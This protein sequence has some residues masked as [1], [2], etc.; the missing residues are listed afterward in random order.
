MAV[1]PPDTP[2]VSCE[3]QHPSY[4]YVNVVVILYI[5]VCIYFIKT[6]KLFSKYRFTVSKYEEIPLVGQSS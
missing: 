2:V 4:V 6:F 5:C 3:F 1:V